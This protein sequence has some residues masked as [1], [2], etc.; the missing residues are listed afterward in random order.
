MT[1]T[2][3]KLTPS[4]TGILPNP[5]TYETLLSFSPLTLI[6]VVP[7]SKVISYSVVSLLNSGLNAT[8]STDKDFK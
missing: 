4:L 8:P 5:V 7:D 2:L 3:I 1:T 6:L